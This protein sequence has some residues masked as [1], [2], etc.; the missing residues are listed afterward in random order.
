[1]SLYAQ[2]DAIHASTA[3]LVQ[4]SAVTP[5][6]DSAEPRSWDPNLEQ[7]EM[8]SP[9]MPL[10]VRKIRLTDV[11]DLRLL[12]PT[13]DL[14]QP[15][16]YL[17][18]FRPV[19]AGLLA[20]L[21]GVRSRRPAFVA[22]VGDRL[23]GLIQFRPQELDE[24]WNVVAIGTAVGVYESDP[25]IEAL[26]EHGVRGAGLRGVK[27]L[28]AKVPH[29]YPLRDAFRRQAWTP[30]ANE[31]IY[32]SVKPLPAR[33]AAIR[34]RAQQ[35]VDT[36]A[37]NQL[38]NAAAP[39]PVQDAEAWT[40]HHWDLKSTKSV[41]T[42]GDTTGWLLEEGHSLL[43]YARIT[44]FGHA[45]LIELVY[46]PDRIDILSS[47]VDSTL[48]LAR[49]RSGRRVYC[50]VRGYQAELASSL[51]DRGFLPGLEQ[52]LLIKYTTATV[53]VPIMEAVPFQLE[54]GEK[55]PQRVPTFLQGSSTD[56]APN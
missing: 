39:K 31:T 22:R 1:M 27:R 34:L 4:D 32:A 3:A 11:P 17:R 28:Y 55:I 37:I 18:G 25:V 14:N 41:S 40:S 16:S 54:V 19:R 26:L 50:A 5:L 46:S 53:R 30:Y 45:C 33:R 48:E 49:L 12:N 36:W 9:P 8:A 51:E 29:D 52:D 15:E 38:Y 42:P 35:P 44:A 24:R 43:G 21:P 13:F 56:G 23:V 20:A 10:T 2:S 6:A 47:L 7:R